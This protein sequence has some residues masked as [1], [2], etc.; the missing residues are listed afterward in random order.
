MQAI[1]DRRSD[2]LSLL[3]ELV[4]TDSTNPN[5]PG[6]TTAAEGGESACNEILCRYFEAAG[7]TPHWVAPN[8]ER[9]NLIGVRRGSGGGRSLLLNGHVDTVAATHLSEWKHGG[10]WGGEYS[11]GYVHGLGSCDMKGGLASMWAVA[12][13][14]ESANVRLRGELQLHSVVGEERMEHEIGTTA[15]LRAGFV[16]DAAV[17]LE[18]TSNPRPLSVASVSAG[19]WHL[20]ITVI[21][22]STHAGNR[23]ASL[24]A[25]SDIGEVGV[26]A[27]EKAVD[28]V[29]ILQTLESNWRHT[30]V[31]PYFPN[32]FFSI[33]PG[34]LKADA[35]SP[36]PFYFPDLAVI[37]YSI[38][39]PPDESAEEIRNEI[40]DFVTTACQLDPWLRDNR[41]RLEWIN[42][43]PSLNT[44]WDEEVVRA[45]CRAR[46]YVTGELAPVS[47]PTPATPLSFGALCD[48]SFIQAFGTPTAVLGPGELSLAHSVNE[49]IDF[50]QV[51]GAARIL[52]H[53]VLDWCEVA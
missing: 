42:N 28:L 18:P 14:L 49:C 53:L 34:L 50:E 33:H 1:E 19:S 13:A 23:A 35:G 48:G 37:E 40:E 11:G 31:H 10:P 47:K 3:R 27:L 39:Y 16:A 46:A 22:K 12:A 29:R 36:I 15:C 5:W 43:W 2:C 7:L 17:V 20:R 44:A 30:K 41:P 9:R 8:P 26:N 6:A 32:G 25:G 4:S 51:I 21:G 52:A 38:M 24:D 45:L